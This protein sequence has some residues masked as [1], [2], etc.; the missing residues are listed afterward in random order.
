MR[1]LRRAGR[2][3]NCRRGYNEAPRKYRGF[4]AWMPNLG[5]PCPA[6]GQTRPPDLPILVQGKTSLR[7]NGKAYEQPWRKTRVIT[8][9]NYIFYHAACPMP[10]AAV[11]FSPP[12][13]R[14]QIRLLGEKE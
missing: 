7:R 9:I 8:M 5:L 12:D 2:R 1:L 3:E 11:D 10:A 4:V 14:R 13:H 6:R